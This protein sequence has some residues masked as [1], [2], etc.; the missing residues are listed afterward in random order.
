MSTRD[1]T[2][3]GY[4]LVL[5]AGIALQ[6]ASVLR[7]DSFPSLGR[8][9]THVMRSRTGRVGI[10]VAWAWVGLHFFAK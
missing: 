5:A 1:G 2:I 3:L 6:V 10:F 9:L 8:V 7:P 4:L